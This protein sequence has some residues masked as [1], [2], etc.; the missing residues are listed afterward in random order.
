M[1]FGYFDDGNREYVIT[2]PDTPEP[3][4]NYL[5]STEYG[6]IIT[7][8]AG[9]YSFYK[10]AAEGR[11][12]RYRTNAV[13]VDQPGRYIYIR[14]MESSDYWSASWQPVGKPLDGYKSECRHGTAYTKITS[15]YADIRSETTYFVPLGK[16]FECWHCK[17]TNTDT[18]KRSL[19]LF[20]FVEYTGHWQ[21]YQDLIN[22]QYS[23]YILTMD[24]VDGIIDHG[25]NV[26]LDEKNDGQARHSFIGIAGARIS[27]FDTDRKR[28]IGYH[29]SYSNPEVVEKGECTNSI[30]LGDNGCGTLQTDIE[31]APG[32]SKEFVVVMGIGKAAS[33]GKQAV[34]FC[35]GLQ[36]V[37]EESEK[38]K[39][40]WHSRLNNMTV[41]SPDAMFNSMM[42]MWSPYNCLLTYAWSRAASLVYA[43]ERDGLG[44]RDSV[45]DLLG[46]LHTIP[47]EAGK[48]LE[49]L[50]T[51]QVSTGGAMPV[52]RQFSHNP[53][54]EKTPKEEEYRSDDCMWLFN[55][56]PAY[57]KET[58]D[59]SFFA[60]IVPYADTGKDSVLNHMKRAIEFSLNR[61]G[62]HGLPCGLLADWNDCLM[63]GQHGESVFVAFQLRYALNV[64]KEI[65]EQL[66]EMQQAGWAET[67]MKKLDENIGRHAWDGKYYLRAYGDDGL[68]YGTQLD[69]EGS[70]WLNPQ[71][72]AVYSGH[73]QGDK[74]VEIL[75]IVYKRLATEYG[76]MICDPPY[77]KAD[78]NVIKATLF[79]KGMKENGA[80][81]CHTQGWAIIAEALTGNG[82]RAFAYFNAYMPAA[83]NDRAEVREIEPYVYSQSI[84]SRYS[85]R[86]GTSRLPWLSGAATWAYYAATQY[87]LGIQPD[88]E[89]I[90]IDPCIPEN[91]D[92]ISITRVFRK[93][94]LNVEIHNAGKSQKGVKNIVVNN[95][96]I[97]GNYIP[98]SILTEVNSVQV[99][100]K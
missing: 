60:K 95:Q 88:Y 8:N 11:F 27:G 32:E 78:V 74:A 86:F 39:K 14:D 23:Q 21:L 66:G 100:M 49:L 20:T 42:N 9:G 38:V 5:G 57:V 76:L 62:K 18:L 83:F 25:T 54:S 58:G 59:I 3:W 15:E 19:R 22:L 24:V 12:L 10:S 79:D 47:E 84:H 50:I 98:V 6:A 16:L 4:S 77:E 28:F 56:I 26:F 7:N 40:Y 63:L 85:P 97:P 29:R 44:Y 80:I 55:T 48:R 75:D 61:S 53:G 93:K 99:Y 34:A 46:V 30:A 73:A 68:K 96:E 91:W 41:N 69:D 2:N 45:Q 82:N 51:G 35:S 70:I 1:E 31:L 13:P 36:R 65:C 17:I 33:E 71:T 43:G 52:V 81:F 90:R 67:E 89:G 92:K 94:V 87:I 37:R 64:Y 72:W